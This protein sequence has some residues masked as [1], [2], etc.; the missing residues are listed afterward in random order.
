M[1]QPVVSRAQDRKP[2]G[3]REWVVVGF[4]LLVAAVVLGVAANDDAGAA[5]TLFTIAAIPGS[6]M[7]TI[8]VVAKAVQVGIRSARD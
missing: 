2:W 6:L 3:P 4:V 5:W 7:V 8:G 1:T